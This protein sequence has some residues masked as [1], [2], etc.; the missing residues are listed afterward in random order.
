MKE[1]VNMLIDLAKKLTGVIVLS[2]LIFGCTKEKKETEEAIVTGNVKALADMQPKDVIV[3][4]NN[5]NLTKSDYDEM[6]VKVDRSFRLN[7]PNAAPGMDKANL[8]NKEKIIVTEYINRCLL[9]DEAGRRG[10]KISDEELRGSISNTV[11]NLTASGKKLEQV[12]VHMGESKEQFENMIRERMLISALLRDEFGENRS[13]VTDEDLKV[14]RDSYVKY[15]ENCA[16]TN[17][18][19]MA[20]GKQ[21][22]EQLKAGADFD[23]VGLATSEEED[24]T[25]VYWGEFNAQEIDDEKVRAAAFNEPIGSV[26][27]PFDT[28]EGLVIIKILRRTAPSAGEG[29]TVEPSVHLGRIF[30]RLGQEFECPDDKELRIEILRERQEEQM[31]PFF[32]KLRKAAQVSFPSGT[33]LWPRAK[34]AGSLR[35]KKESKV[36]ELE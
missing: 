25:S 10:I 5:Y 31:R 13:V 11:K 17:Q 14:Q 21:I 2:L 30:L 6:L 16:A 29:E 36:D 1:N 27:G 3:S 12:L 22:V 19:A 24:L 33:N 32:E 9:L 15:N 8:K 4:I 35:S 20:R 23:T 7:N 34:K 28:E 26:A 18:L